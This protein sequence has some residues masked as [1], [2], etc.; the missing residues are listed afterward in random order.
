VSDNEKST[1]PGLTAAKRREFRGHEAR[2]AIADH[3]KT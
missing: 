3:Q 2:K 1:D